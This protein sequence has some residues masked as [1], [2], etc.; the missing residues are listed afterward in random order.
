VSFYTC[1]HC[2]LTCNQPNWKAMY[3]R[4]ESERQASARSPSS[5]I[6]SLRPSQAASDN[7]SSSG[8]LELPDHSTTLNS[9][10]YNSTARQQPSNIA[11]WHPNSLGSTL[12]KS[13]MPTS[14][15]SQQRLAGLSA[16]LMPV[17]MGPP[18]QNMTAS[19]MAGNSRAGSIAPGQRDK[20]MP[21]F[22]P[23]GPNRDSKNGRT[24]RFG[25]K[26]CVSCIGNAGTPDWR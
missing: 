5:S 10:A 9:F 13:V 24:V 16:E 14:I 23:T 3:L 22:P 11:P 26:D 25:K 12:G 19:R 6:Q 7:A 21:R 2:V 20:A 15:E 1:S 4:L 17:N 18:G 8:T